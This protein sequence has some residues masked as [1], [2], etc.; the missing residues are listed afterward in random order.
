[1]NKPTLYVYEKGGSYSLFKEANRL[2]LYP[3]THKHPMEH[4]AWVGE[5]TPQMGDVIITSS[6]YLV[7]ALARC[8]GNKLDY[9]LVTESGEE[10]EGLATIFENFYA[11]FEVFEDLDRGLLKGE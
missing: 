4:L 8:F 7:E 10:I 1:M 11:P 5:Y 3:E 2:F 6:P 9:I